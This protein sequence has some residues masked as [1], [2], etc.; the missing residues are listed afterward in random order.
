M[1][2][3]LKHQQAITWTPEDC[4]TDDLEMAGFGCSDTVKYGTAEDGTLVL[5]HHPVFPTLRVRPN[6]THAS[7]QMDMPEGI[8]LYCDG[9]K[10]R[11]MPT[12]FRIDGVLH[13]TSRAGDLQI[14]R[15]CYP[16]ATARASFEEI[17]ITNDGT[18]SVSI[19]TDTP[20]SRIVGET[21]GPMGVNVA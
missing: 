16:A 2:W 18:Q 1:R 5:I 21:M 9:E 7:W 20:Q 3:T 10:L 12:K 13:I 11:E 4:H 19:T 14:H 15:T 6:D 8:A 17:R